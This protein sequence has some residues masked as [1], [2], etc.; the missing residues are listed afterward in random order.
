MSDACQVSLVGHGEHLASVHRNGETGAALRA[1]HPDA[2]PGQSKRL[3][4]PISPL[5]LQPEPHIPAENV[6]HQRDQATA[7]SP[8]RSP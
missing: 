3:F 4:C 5:L 7:S 2:V 1:G 8:A 6:C